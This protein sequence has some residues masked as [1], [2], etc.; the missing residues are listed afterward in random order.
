MGLISNVECCTVVG[1]P[2]SYKIYCTEPFLYCYDANALGTCQNQNSLA[3]LDHCAFESWLI[4]TLVGLGLALFLCLSLCFYCCC[5]RHTSSPGRTVVVLSPGQGNRDQGYVP[6]LDSN[7][8]S[9]NGA[10]TPYYVAG[11]GSNTYSKSD[12]YN[13]KSN[14][15][16]SSSN[17]YG[18]S[19]NNTPYYVAGQSNAAESD[20]TSSYAPWT[21]STHG[22]EYQY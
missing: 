15:Y 16:N 12:T 6:L 1:L 4:G 7:T 18:S 9:N 21:A 11:G 13:S 8:N 14:T 5:C 22:K 20:T 17:T 3:V 19:S 10:N 2:A